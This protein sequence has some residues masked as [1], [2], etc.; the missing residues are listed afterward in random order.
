MT[1]EEWDEFFVNLLR[2]ILKDLQESY[3][4]VKKYTLPEYKE[5]CSDY[6]E[7]ISLLKKVVSN[8]SSIDDLEELSGE[9]LD[10]IYEDIYDYASN[11]VISTENKEQ[12]MQTYSNIE[13]I[14]YMFVDEEY[15]ENE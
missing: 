14:L 7:K 10:S 3:D 1:D 11:F 2:D 13:E 6:E 9:D 5:I 8:T 15:E 12:D 4:S